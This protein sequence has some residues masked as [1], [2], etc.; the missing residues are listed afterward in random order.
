MFLV[1]KGLTCKVL[2]SMRYESASK[3]ATQLKNNRGMNSYTC[4]VIC[5]QKH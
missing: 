1:C 4:T 5:I 2:S 3:N